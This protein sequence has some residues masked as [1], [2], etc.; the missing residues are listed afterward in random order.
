MS[1]YGKMF[2]YDLLPSNIKKI[3]FFDADTILL[4]DPGILYDTNVDNFIVGAVKDSY[5]EKVPFEMKKALALG[6]DDDYF[7]SGVMIVNL[8]NWRKN[9]VTQKA[10][11]FMIDFGHKTLFHD[12][13]GFNYA[14]NGNWKRISPL[15]NPSSIN[16]IID[17]DGRK[18]ELTAKQIYERG[19]AKL[20]H[21]HGSNKPW[22]Y[23]SDHIMKKA[24]LDIL[25]ETQFFDYKFPD[26]NVINTIR[27]VYNILI[28]KLLSIIK[29]LN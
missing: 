5:Y 21:F 16:T 17:H 25:H 6:S 8:E 29:S 4:E 15:W 9:E 14:I 23:M 27:K 28:L 19:L 18:I 10:L 24:Y 1:I 3:A 22:L 7:N 11:N 12:Q 20:V 13:D 2:I 26:K